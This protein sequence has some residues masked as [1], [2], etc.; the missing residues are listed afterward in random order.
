MAGVFYGAT[1]LP[2][3]YIQDNP[4]LFSSVS[5]R[6]LPYVF[7]H[8]MGIFLTS[9]LFFVLYALFRYVIL[10]SLKQRIFRRNDPVINPRMALPSLC[11]G[12][13]C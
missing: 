1:F 5:D 9:T 12:T 8:F 10:F 4:D 2:V 13:G 6:G 3:T 11:S 7:S